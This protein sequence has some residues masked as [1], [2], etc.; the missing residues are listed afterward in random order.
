MESIHNRTEFETFPLYFV[1]RSWGID[2]DLVTPKGCQEIWPMLN[3]EDIVGGLWIPGDGVGDPHLI[4][5]S[6]IREALQNGM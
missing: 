5:M 3:V 1:N 6:L 2:C 4:C